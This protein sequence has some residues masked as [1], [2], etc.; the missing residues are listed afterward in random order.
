MRIQCFEII[1][2]LCW[3]EQ[4]TTK[5]DNALSKRVKDEWETVIYGSAYQT[6]LT[7]Q[8]T[9]VNYSLVTTLTT[10]TWKNQ[11]RHN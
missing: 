6:D 8:C 2:I 7:N 11:Y 10:E 5:Y 3:V 9:Y 4:L 1:F